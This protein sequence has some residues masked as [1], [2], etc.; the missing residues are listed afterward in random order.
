MQTVHNSI[1]PVSPDYRALSFSSFYS[2]DL[3][4]LSPHNAL[5]QGG[6]GGSMEGGESR[7]LMTLQADYMPGPR[8]TRCA[9]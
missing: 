5:G 8:F 7:T 3:I 6:Q 2:G 4:P 1:P 9:M